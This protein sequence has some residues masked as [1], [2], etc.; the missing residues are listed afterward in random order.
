M[1][2]TRAQEFGV[3]LTPGNHPTLPFM[4]DGVGC[5]VPPYLRVLCTLHT[6][7]VNSLGFKRGDE[8][9]TRKYFKL[10]N[11]IER[12]ELKRVAG[13]RRLRGAH[14]PEHEHPNNSQRGTTNE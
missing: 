1:A 10:R 6:C 9:W 12:A 11:Q 8:P 2:V 5:T 7:E 13:R 14:G 3:T 4:V